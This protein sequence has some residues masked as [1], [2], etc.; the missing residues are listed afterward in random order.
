MLQVIRPVN[1]RH[2]YPFFLIHYWCIHY[3][4]QGQKM[5][6]QKFDDFSMSF[7]VFMF[8]LKVVYSKDVTLRV[9]NS[10]HHNFTSSVLLNVI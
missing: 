5:M 8:F 4:S 9:Y 6:M 2:W 1:K 3:L 10:V 7:K